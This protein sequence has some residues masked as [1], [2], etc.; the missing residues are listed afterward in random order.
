MLGICLLIGY[1]A[2][3]SAAADTVYL[4]AAE[5]ASY[6]TSRE[7]CAAGAEYQHL[8][9]LHVNSRMLCQ[10]AHTV[11]IC[12][13]P[14]QLVASP[15]NGI[16]RADVLGGC[17]YLIEQRHYLLLIWNSYVQPEKIALADEALK[18]SARYLAQGIAVFSYHV[19]SRQKS[20]ARAAR[21]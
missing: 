9:A 20:C 12:V 11:K 13:V 16:Y 7:R 8:F 1:C 21:L 15:H 2:V 14:V 19:G 3:A 5:A 17:I 4:A 6:R 18:T 10:T